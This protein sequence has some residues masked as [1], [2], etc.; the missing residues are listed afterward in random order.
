MGTWC[1]CN[2][3]EQG[4]DGDRLKYFMH[5]DLDE[6]RRDELEGKFWKVVTEKPKES[7]AGEFRIQLEWLGAN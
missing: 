7:R 2:Y 5:P 1:E 4:T 3:D 6:F